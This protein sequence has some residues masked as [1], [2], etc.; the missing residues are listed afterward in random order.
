MKKIPSSKILITTSRNPTQTIRTFCNDLACSIP[1]SLKINRGKSSL[2][3]LAEKA[4]EFEAEKIV[5]SDRWKGG[6]GKIQLFEMVTMGLVQFYPL[7]YVREAKLRKVFGHI[8]TETKSLA[9]QTADGI[10]FETQ[11][12]AEALS[13]FFNIPKLSSYEALP[14]DIQG[15]MYISFNTA[16]R[17]QVTFLQ[18]PQRI[19]V[20]PQI[21]VSHLIWK[22]KK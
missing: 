13:H 16:R 22:S 1:N 10:P 9:L 17:I 7:I 8:R 20:G 14:S 21:T 15:T 2:D 18:T 11:K 5:I 12:L 3:A 4:L 6:L 19:E